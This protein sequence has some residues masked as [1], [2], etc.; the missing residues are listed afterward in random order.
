MKIEGLRGRMILDSRGVPT[1]EATIESTKGSVTASVPAGTSTGSHEAVELRDGDRRW[2]GQGVSKAVS[3]VTAEL[4]AAVKGKNLA[5]QAALDELLIKTDGTPDKSRL[6]ANAILA[7]SLAGL[8]AFAAEAGQPLWQFAAT[9]AGLPRPAQLPVP[10][11]NVINGGAHADNQLDVQEFMLVPRGFERFADAVRAVTETYQVLKTALAG[12]GAGTGVGAEGG[13]APNLSSHTEVLDLLVAAIG[14]AGY[15]SGQEIAIGLDVA[16]SEFLKDGSYVFE[17]QALS[18]DQMVAQYASLLESYPLVSLE[19]PLAEDDAAGWERAASR[20]KE[21]VQLVGDDLTVTDAKRISSAAEA[22]LISAV[23]L[24]PNQIGT[25]TETW[26]AL[27]AARA[28][29]VTPIISH[30]SGETD[31]D[32]IADLAVGWGVPQVKIG[33]PAR[34]ERVAKYNRLLEIESA[35]GSSATYAGKHFPKGAA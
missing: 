5:D 23:I 15:E 18:A 28:G 13:F 22:G 33:A 12:R 34:G 25:V 30:R 26:R 24:K 31:D 3:H 16:A 14:E 1:V 9:A 6:G 32:V 35:I 27:V 7:V 20:L 11:A 19:D 10:L 21:S 29:N 2:G 8:K 17:G 4:A